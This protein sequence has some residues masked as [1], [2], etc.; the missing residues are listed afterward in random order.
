MSVVLEV[1]KTV[2]YLSALDYIINNASNIPAV[3]LSC[4]HKPIIYFNFDCY[5]QFSF[6]FLLWATASF[7]L[8][9]LLFPGSLVFLFRISLWLILISLLPLLDKQKA[10]FL[11][12]ISFK[13]TAIFGLSIRRRTVSSLWS[14]NI[15]LIKCVLKL[16][17]II[18]NKLCKTL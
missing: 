15:Y 18:R 3:R 14:V 17:N 2:L 1:V 12:T 5:F 4:T 8:N 6:S 9:I 11:I 7:Q 10:C 16:M 13:Q